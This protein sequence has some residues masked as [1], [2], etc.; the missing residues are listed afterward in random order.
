MP[1]SRQAKNN[2]ATLGDEVVSSSSDEI[3]TLGQD[4]RLIDNRYVIGEPAGTFYQN[5]RV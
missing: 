4:F 1:N 5:L 2:F 3:M